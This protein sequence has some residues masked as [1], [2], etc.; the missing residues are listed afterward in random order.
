[1]V[2]FIKTLFLY[3]IPDKQSFLRKTGVEITVGKFP[4]L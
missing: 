4:L 3:T 2:K 1:M